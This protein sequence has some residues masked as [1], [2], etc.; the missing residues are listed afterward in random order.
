MG[1]DDLAEMNARIYDPKWDT[2]ERRNLRDAYDK[3]Y[4]ADIRYLP[5]SWIGIVGPLLDTVAEAC[6]GV[7][8]LQ[9]K[10]KFGTLRVYMEP[11][12]G[13][14]EDAV[15]T[16]ASISLIALDVYVER[17]DDSCCP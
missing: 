12:D 16:L 14:L 3:K 10:E 11:H 15:E 8:F 7:R 6:P 13:E 9:V 1:L 4:G 2:Q 17:P 5:V